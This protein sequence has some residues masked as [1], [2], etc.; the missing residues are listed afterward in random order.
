MAGRCLFSNVKCIIE[1]FTKF[2]SRLIIMNKNEQPDEYQPPI[3]IAAIACFV[4]LVFML[5][6][7]RPA[8]MLLD[9]WW[10][11]LLVF[12]MLPIFITFAILYRSR[13]HR[14]MGRLTR[15]LSMILHSCIISCS[16]SLAGGAI[17]TALFVVVNRFTAFHY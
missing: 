10:A 12:A 13:W 16:V 8:V 9:A 2:L 4:Y 6:V 11:E 3:G 14:E 1:R 17:I 5:C 15:I 7:A